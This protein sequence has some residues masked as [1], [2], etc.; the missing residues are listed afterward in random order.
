MEIH[1]NSKSKTI[2]VGTVFFFS[3]KL[4]RFLDHRAGLKTR[5]VVPVLST[6]YSVE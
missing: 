3:L 1:K 2:M 6:E 5:E 4:I